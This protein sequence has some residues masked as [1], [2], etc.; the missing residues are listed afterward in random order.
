LRATAFLL[1]IAANAACV[2]APPVPTE[3]DV[4]IARATEPSATLQQLV[5]GLRLFIHRCGGC[6]ALYQPTEL[7]RDEWSAAVDEMKE[8]AKLTDA[9]RREILRYVLTASQSVPGHA[10]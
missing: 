2:T 7:P 6:H 4:Q 10:P 1:S 3:R 5:D 8:R 9:Q